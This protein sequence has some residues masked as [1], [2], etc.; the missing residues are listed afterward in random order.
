M[1]ELKCTCYIEWVGGST[2]GLHY[3]EHMKSWALKADLIIPFS[4]FIY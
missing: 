4:Y 2:C 3:T 1:S